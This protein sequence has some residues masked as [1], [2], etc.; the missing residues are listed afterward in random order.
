MPVYRKI[1]LDELHL[2][3]SDLKILLLR[4]YYKRPIRII[5]DRWKGFK[6]SNKR[7]MDALA[8]L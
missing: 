6:I 5:E 3:L 8:R 7:G 2:W 1:S 4:I